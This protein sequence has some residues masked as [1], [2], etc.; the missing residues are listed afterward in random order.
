M[1]SVDYLITRYLFAL[2]ATEWTSCCKVIVWAQS[3]CCTTNGI[4]LYL[5]LTLTKKISSWGVAPLLRPRWLKGSCM[6]WFPVGVD[7]IFWRGFPQSS[8]RLTHV[9]GGKFQRRK[10]LSSNI[11]PK[12]ACVF[13]NCNKILSSY[14][15]QARWVEV[16]FFFGKKNIISYKGSGHQITVASILSHS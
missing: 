4:K 9:R 12:C 13:F 16:Y 5:H 14:I 3:C 8:F 10:I 15:S 1:H 11:F 7:V 6:R 2:V